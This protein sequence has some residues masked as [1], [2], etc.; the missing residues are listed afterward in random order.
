[1]SIPTLLALALVQGDPA[2]P[3]GE[4]VVTAPRAGEVATDS[5]ASKTVLTGEDL[6]RTGA[7]T[8]PKAIAR[9]SGGWVQETNLGGGS[10]FLRGVTGNQVL[11]LLDGMRIN[12][13]TTRFGPNQ[14]LNTIDPAIVDRVE[15]QRGPVSVLY[16]SD[17]IGGVV[18]IWTKRRRTARGDDE[19]KG[20]VPGGDVVL[21][22]AVEGGRLTARASDA[23]DDWSWLSIVSGYDFEDLRAGNGEVQEFT[24]Y[25]GAAAFVSFEHDLSESKSLR[26]TSLYNRDDDVPR[27]DRLT[28]GF[29]SDGTLQ[30]EPRNEIF[31]FDV[32]ER[33]AHQ[34]TYLDSQPG[35]GLDQLQ[36]RLSYRSYLEERERLRTGSTTFRDERD[37]VDTLGT[38]IEAQK[39]LGENHLLTF[40]FDVNNDEVT[41][42]RTDI[43]TGTMVATPR[44]GTFAPDARYTRMGV[45]LRDEIFAWEAVDVTAGLRYSYYDFAF[46]PFPSDVMGGGSP[47]RISGDFDALTGSLQVAGDLSDTARLTGT[48]AQGFR[49]PNLDDLAKNGEFNAGTELANPNLSPEEA[50]SFGLDLDLTRPGWSASVG[51]FYTEIDDVVGRVP[52]AGFD[53]GDPMYDRANVGEVTLWGAEASWEQQLGGADSE[54]SWGGNVTWTR[55]EQNDDTVDPSTMMPIF[56]GVPW[57]R[58]PPL[59]GAVRTAFSPDDDGLVDRAQFEVVWAGRQDRLHPDD[60]S[61]SRIDPNGT[62]GW[63]ILNLDFE[64]ALAGGSTRWT[65]GLHNLLD[66]NYRVHGSGFDGPGLELVLGLHWN[67]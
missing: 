17:A 58:V 32:Q 42:S 31:N 11:I 52:V 41:S 22:T 7:T 6:R 40:G 44:D 20:F 37:E 24:G 30:T 35:G 49:A 61:D 67:P 8:L 59:Y 38:S 21:R 27:T 29:N 63:A 64:G 3:T 25:G 66:K 54:W 53:P 55:G 9:A 36:W 12:D 62:G 1:M 18:A 39:A 5:P 33:Q 45:F 19:A 34:F 65:L 48:V 14:S 28:I 47:D 16:G 60:I 26:F 46:D 23:G 2:A 13:S 10:I 43:D 57:R 15:I 56:D 50:T 4:T 51:G